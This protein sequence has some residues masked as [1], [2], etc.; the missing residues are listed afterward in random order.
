MRRSTTPI[1]PVAGL[2]ALAIA[3]CSGA[4]ASPSGEALPT[5]GAPSASAPA[6]SGSADASP[7]SGGSDANIEI[8]G[9]EYAFENVPQ[10]AEIG[11]T[12][13]FTNDG[14][15]VHELVLVR[16]NE[17]VDLSFEDLLA[18]PEEEVMDLITMV[19]PVLIAEPGAA[20]DGEVTLDEPGDYLMVCFIPQGMRELP[21]GSFDPS[22][23]PA[24][25]PHFTAGMLAEFRVDG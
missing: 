25:P 5:A 16:R 2:L 21:E 6:P 18:M 12:V 9:V 19:E 13:S 17:G 23:V 4:G 24:G 22:A 15:E 20:A 8:V 1:L 10:N 3:A 7:S 14:T 11:T